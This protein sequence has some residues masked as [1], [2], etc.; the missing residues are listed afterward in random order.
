MELNQ[1]MCT[2]MK[3]H[4]SGIDAK[5]W[6]VRGINQLRVLPLL[7]DT[8]RNIL[9]YT[10]DADDLAVLVTSGSCIQKHFNASAGLSDE[11]KFKVGRLDTR[12]GLVQY[13]LH[14]SL[15]IF[16]DEL[17]NERMTYRKECLSA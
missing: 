5:D 11:R 16:R 3:T 6:S 2:Q 12:E 4:P 9:A 7:S 13:S 15:V 1:R 14:G 17:L 10:H 8:T